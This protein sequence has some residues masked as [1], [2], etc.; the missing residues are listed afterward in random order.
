MG[1][2]IPI[3][4]D[5]LTAALIR[6]FSGIDEAIAKGMY[7]GAL[8]GQALLSHRTPK[9]TGGAAA[10]WKVHRPASAKG[11]KGKASKIM[12]YL[13]NDTPYVAVLEYGARPHRVSKEG[14]MALT[15]WAQLKLGLTP[16]EAERVAHAIAWKIRKRG[17]KPLYFVRDSR[18]E[19]AA[20]TGR[21]IR[22]FIAELANKRNP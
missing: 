11:S 21:E 4:P 16:E 9:Y 8:Y 20:Q 19:I 12:V 10:R 15:R 5:K 7:H 6:R 22:Q 17:M 1:V 3:T 14:V 2:R 18:D 13:E